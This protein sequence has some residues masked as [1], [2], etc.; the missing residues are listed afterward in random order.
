[1]VHRPASIATVAEALRVHVA[2][3]QAVEDSEVSSRWKVRDRRLHLH[4][5]AGSQSPEA[6]ETFCRGKLPQGS[7][8]PT[9][10]MPFVRHPPLVPAVPMRGTS[11]IA[12]RSG[13][14]GRMQAQHT[15]R[16]NA[17]HVSAKLSSVA[18]GRVRHIPS[19][20]AAERGMPRHCQEQ[21]VWPA[22]A[23]SQTQGR[24]RSCG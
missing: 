4:G 14:E 17:A 19:R 18:G 6:P 9:Q 20:V 22:E 11:T 21:V 3:L 10:A 5:H 8:A 24:P 7:A 1:M 15:Q 2:L 13:M 23:P 12:L 16:W